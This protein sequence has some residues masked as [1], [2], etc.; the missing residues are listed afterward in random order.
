MPKFALED[1]LDKVG[2]MVPTLVKYD[3]LD[4]AGEEWGNVQDFDRLFD[5]CVARWGRDWDLDKLIATI[6]ETQID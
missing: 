1:R 6:S 5:A 3:D 4:P 2:V